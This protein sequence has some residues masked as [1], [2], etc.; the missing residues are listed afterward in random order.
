MRTIKDHLAIGCAIAVV[1]ASSIAVG[2]GSSSNDDTTHASPD[3]ARAYVIDHLKTRLS[4][5]TRLRPVYRSADEVLGNV[6]Y[7][8]GD[9]PARALTDAV[10]VGAIRDVTPGYGFADPST[11]A[12][13]EMVGDAVRVP[14]DSPEALWRTV[15]LTIDVDEVV[16]GHIPNG[17]RQIRVGLAI[18][19]I[20]ADEGQITEGLAA[21]GSTVWFLRNDSPVFAYD[22]TLYS[23]L[24][25]G[26]LIAPVASDGSLLFPM[27]EEGDPAEVA[28]RGTTLSQLRAAANRSSRTVQLHHDEGIWLR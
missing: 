2:C 10:I 7:V 28:L 26:R 16:S 5:F 15:H 6:R 19:N 27:L 24:E 14:F 17:S 20:N 12:E 22:S 13:G 1:A 23:D 11:G 9:S 18:G 25:D 4:A 21:L 8:Q 3:H